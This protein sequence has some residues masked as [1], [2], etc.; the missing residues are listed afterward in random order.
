MTPKYTQETPE[1]N[2]NQNPFYIFQ[3]RE[4]RKKHKIWSFLSALFLKSIDL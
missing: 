3:D 2:F 4:V 1:I